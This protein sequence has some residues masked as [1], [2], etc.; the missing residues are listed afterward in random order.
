M[1]RATPLPPA[2][3][4]S[5]LIGATLPL[6]ERYGREVSTRQIAEAAG[7]A[8]GTIFRVFPSKE[9]LID[10]VIADAFDVGR[11]VD[12]LEAVPST[13]DLET[14]LVG[15]VNVLQRRLRRVFGLF[16]ALR[17]QR[18][19]PPDRAEHQARQRNDNARIDAALADLLA[20]DRHRLRLDPLEVADLL[21]TMTFAMSHPILN[22]S[23]VAD[24][25]R[26]VDLVLHGVCVPQKEHQTC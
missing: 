9:A 22:E 1:P 21:R 17:L 7:V 3:R 19:V 20:P 25:T 13:G 4:R 11:T 24:P 14:R 23:G 26:I 8:E 2:E 10:A 15:A 18:E 16:H 5:E 6:I 12:A